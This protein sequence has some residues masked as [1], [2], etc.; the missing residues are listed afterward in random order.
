MGEQSNILC[1]YLD[2][3]ERFADLFNGRFFGGA[4]VV[5]PEDLQ[6]ASGSY[7]GKEPGQKGGYLRLRD[8]KKV[9]K[10]ILNMRGW[11]KTRRLLSA[12]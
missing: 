10:S 6:E 4:K 7:S 12:G 5:K 8:I 1:G 2:D 11:M 3:N 9:L